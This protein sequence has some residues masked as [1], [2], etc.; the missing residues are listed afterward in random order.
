MVGGTEVPRE[1]KVHETGESK[2]EECTSEDE[3]EDEVVGF[4]EADGVVDLTD[5]SIGRVFGWAD[6]CNHGD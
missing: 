4:T 3:I 2:A 5:P 6:R 1:I